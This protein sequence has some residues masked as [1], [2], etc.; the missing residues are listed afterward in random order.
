MLNQNQKSQGE[1]IYNLTNARAAANGKPVKVATPAA[2]K[3]DLSHLPLIERL[4]AARK[5]MAKQKMATNPAPTYPSGELLWVDG[6]CM[7][8]VAYE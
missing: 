6:V 7:G 3:D 4:T 1:L 2:P 5:R 8:F